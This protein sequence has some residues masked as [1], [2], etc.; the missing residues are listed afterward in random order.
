MECLGIVLGLNR[1]PSFPVDLGVLLSLKVPDSVL[2]LW[3][4]VST[5]SAELWAFV[6]PHPP[7]FSDGGDTWIL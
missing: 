1:T 4:A 6:A 5:P 2:R 3:D 7:T